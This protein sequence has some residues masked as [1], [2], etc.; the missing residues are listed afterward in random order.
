MEIISVILKNFKTHRDRQFEFKPGTNAICG[1]NGAGKTSI[2]EAIGWTLFN[3][4][5]SYTKDDLIRNGASSAQATVSFVSSRD[6]RTYDVQRCT[7]RGY[8]L[9]D[10]QLGQRLP[11]TRIESEVLP[12]LRQHLGLSPA[13]GLEQ[14]F[15]NTIGVP[16]GTFT[17]DFQLPI[18]KR[19]QVFDTVLKV[20]E[21][22]QLYSQLASLKR[23][24]EGQAQL[25]AQAI[26]QYE[27]TLAGLDEL[28]PQRQQLAESIETGDA[29]IQALGTQLQALTQEQGQLAQ[30]AEDLQQRR[31]QL[32]T[33]AT[34]LDGKRREAALQ[35]EAVA[36]SQGAQQQ[37]KAHRAGHD[38]FL[39]AEA[40]L[41]QMGE[42]L[43]QQTELLQARQG[44]QTALAAADAALATVKTKLEQVEQASQALEQLRPQALQQAA[45]EQTQAQLDQRQRQM[46]QQRQERDRLKRER[47]R[48]QAEADALAKAVAQIEALASV[49]ETIPTL[50]QQQERL[51]TQISRVDAAKQFEADLRQLVAQCAH[52]Q[53]QYEDEAGHALTVLRQLQAAAPLLASDAVDAAL[54]TLESGVALNAS[55]IQSLD[56]ILTDLSQQTSTTA[57]SS[58]LRST[59]AQLDQAY[60]DRARY[61]TLAE[62][63]DRHQQLGQT[64]KTLRE[65]VSQLEAALKDEQ[66]VTQQWR[67]AQAALKALDNP[68]A[69]VALLERQQQQ[70]PAL[71]QSYQ[72]EKTV[73]GE[74]EVAIATLDQQLAQFADLRSRQQAQAQVRDTHRVS[75]L[76]YLQQQP[77][78]QQL[79]HRK[80]ALSEVE[81]QVAQLA[82]QQQEQQQ[83]YGQAKAAYNAERRQQVETQ[84]RQLRSEA[85]RLQGQLPQ[86]HQRLSELDHRLAQLQAVSQTCDRARTDLKQK[87]RIKR[88][89]NF[90]RKVYKEAGPR[91]TERYVYTVSQE[92][93]RL[94]RELLNRPNVALEWTRDYDV[95][96]QEGAHR[97]RFVNLSGGEQMCAALAVRLAL[98]RVL[99]DIDIAF[100]DEPTTNMDRRRRQG[101]AE[102]IANIKSFRQ[103]FVIS[104]DD[105]FEQYTE[106]IVF[107]ERE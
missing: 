107:V 11:Y 71:A 32:Q 42:Q 62:T 20:G 61:G 79:E 88:F 78:S 14:L 102:A 90:A 4:S 9:Y 45:L 16:Q 35:S 6:G 7:S 83:A 64:L 66:A 28:Q 34:Q 25:V 52:Q 44:Q 92:A 8:T 30:Q 72:K 43:G 70:Q 15:K 87:E 81:Q 63:R 51:R 58:Q 23:Y 98:L 41:K 75:Y 33:L 86:Q 59:A 26:A 1:E 50:E 36:R 104:H 82:Q 85:D 18:E 99:A 12:W 55:V 60:R 31:A 56:V 49:L 10:P 40:V 69:R 73:R 13:T 105:T 96:V 29:R 74:V 68:R 76:T 37:C 80:V 17:A 19:K 53:Q 91:I 93:N 95:V 39:E 103:L 100:F 106:N 89:I 48:L 3:Y 57:L 46:Q 97:R 65:Q 38:A 54:A 21:Y 5:S 101:L 84:V 24:G 77:E 94:F 2:L 47:A 22:K 27:E 67:D